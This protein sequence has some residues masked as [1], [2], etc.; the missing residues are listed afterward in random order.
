MD[1]YDNEELTEAE[2]EDIRRERA[3]ARR[4]KLAARERRRKKRRQQAIIRCSILLVAV[5]LVIFIIV[6]LITGI[7]GLFTKDKK[8]TTTTEAPT[9][10]QVTTEPPVAE[11]DE[12]I[13]AKDLPADRAT[14]LASLQTLAATDTEIK[15]IVDNE[16][17]Y[18]DVVIRN[19]AAN[20]ELK[21]FT[22]DYIAKIN[23]VYD[24]NFTM[25]VNQTGVPLFLQ[26]DEEWGYADYANDLVA[27]SGSAPTCLSMAYTYLKQDGSMNPIKVADY[28][29]EKGYVDEH[30]D[31]NWAL[32]TEGAAGLGL[33]AETLTVSE[34]DM[35]T[36]L[37]E[38]KV[39]ICSMA[40]GDFT[41]SGSYIVI[42][43]YKDGLFY[44]NDP[45][46]QA[47]S[48]VGWD[49][50]RLSEQITNMWA[51]TV[52]S[53]D[54]TVTDGANSTDG[55]TSTTGTSDTTSA[56]G[57]TTGANDATSTTS[58]TTNTQSTSDTT[59]SSSTN[60]TSSTTAGADDPQAAN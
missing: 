10:Q 3:A 7:V 21:Q 5:I 25:D 42:R 14:A 19:L 31:T 40:P 49:F 29:T 56:T 30:G 24:G 43:D 52:G 60:T 44:V 35:K 39:I 55:T 17:V 33:S 26:Y 51:F 16:A 1:G 20:T 2:L 59:T 45:T 46:S 28:S 32:M 27:Y 9:T 38:G 11:I 12:N 36:S 54:A 8:K 18:P 47:R 23:T 48:D 4:R 15:S 13:L 57:S 53:T 6:K 58:S 34:D 41:R 37:E 22:L 50:K